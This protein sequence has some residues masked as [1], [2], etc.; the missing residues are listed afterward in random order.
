MPHVVRR[1]GKV[2]ACILEWLLERTCIQ[3]NTNLNWTLA[4]RLLCVPL[5]F[6]T[7]RRCGAG[8]SS[9]G[10]IVGARTIC[11][12]DQ[13]MVQDAKKMNTNL[14]VHTLVSCLFELSL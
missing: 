5:S 10:K 14:L 7:H 4:S 1:E 13:V 11:F 3:W 6:S 9:A 8:C 2:G 12:K